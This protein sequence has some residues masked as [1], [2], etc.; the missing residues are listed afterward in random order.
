MNPTDWLPFY[1]DLL[2][3]RHRRLGEA[4]ASRPPYS[5]AIFPVVDVLASLTFLPAYP[6][7]VPHLR[8]AREQMTVT[9][10]AIFVTAIAPLAWLS[11]YPDRVPHRYLPWGAYPEV[12]AP[13]LGYQMGVA[14]SLS[15]QAYAPD[16]VARQRVPVLGGLTWTIDPSLLSTCCVDLGLEGAA[17][18]IFLASGL[19]SP[20]FLGEGLGIPA[21]INEDLC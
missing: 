2:P 6:D 8:V 14:Q 19:T 18:S 10:A 12:T 11:H 21:L 4:L 7:R 15:W 5:A 3:R 20:A 16:R 1:P 17:S 9:T 13:P